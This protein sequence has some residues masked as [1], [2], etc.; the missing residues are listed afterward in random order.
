MYISIFHCS[1]LNHLSDLCVSKGTAVQPV[2]MQVCQVVLD[3]E[4]IEVLMQIRCSC[5]FV[6]VLFVCMSFIDY[7]CLFVFY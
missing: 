6:C 3:E 7:I 5:L 4:N 1:Y 2:Q